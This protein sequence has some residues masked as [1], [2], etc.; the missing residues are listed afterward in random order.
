MCCFLV[1]FSCVLSSA[2]LQIFVIL[3]KGARKVLSSC[4]V[5]VFNDSALGQINRLQYIDRLDW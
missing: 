2:K 5:V 4:P 1:L 3:I